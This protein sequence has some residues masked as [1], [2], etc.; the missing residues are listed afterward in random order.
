[1][2]VALT[3]TVEKAVT[4]LGMWGAMRAAFPLTVA[5]L[6][7]VLLLESL[8]TPVS[9]LLPRAPL[10]A[11]HAVAI[12]AGLLLG[13]FG[14]FL[15]EF[16]DRRVFEATYGPQG[17]WRDA[18]SRPLSLF[19]AGAPLTKSRSQA[20]HAMKVEILD[21]FYRQAVK[22]ARRQVERWEQVEH[23]LILSWSARG[24]LGPC[25]VAAVVAACAAGAAALLGVRSELPRL[26]AI[27]LGSLLLG[28]LLLI[29]YADHRME[30]MLRLYQ[31]VATHPAKKK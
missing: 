31:D 27:G 21:G 6:G 3:T 19:P 24:L 10:N 26:L 1:M 15:G 9:R 14:H 18:V 8:T 16:W 25:L 22:L 28:A 17:R 7:S 23:P 29:C 13:L 20:A 5:L 11:I 30:H 12:G 4:R 2:D